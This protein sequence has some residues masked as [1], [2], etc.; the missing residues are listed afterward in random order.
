M[1]SH[2]GHWCLRQRTNERFFARRLRPKCV[3]MPAKQREVRLQMMCCLGRRLRALL[4]D[5][6]HHPCAVTAAAAIAGMAQN[7]MH[8]AGPSS[9]ESWRQTGRMY[10]Y[11]VQHDKSWATGK[12]QALCLL[13]RV[14]DWRCD[15]SQRC[16]GNLLGEEMGRGMGIDLVAPGKGFRWLNGNG[17]SGTALECWSR[18]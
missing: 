10:P 18:S 12:Q 5:D 9:S 6:G 15:L 17:V 7:V 4:M 3:D 1:T 13:T 16:G 11:S 2:C 14:G 8:L